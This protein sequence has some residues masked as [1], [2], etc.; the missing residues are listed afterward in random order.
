MKNLL[1]LLLS[2]SS[3]VALSQKTM[4]VIHLNNDGLI[5]GTILEDSKERIRIKTHNGNIFVFKKDEVRLV[6]K[7]P[8]VDERAIKTK[9]YINLTSAGVLVG[10]TANELRA[11]FSALM[12]HN[13]R[14]N[15]YVALGLVSG[16]EMLN[17]AT[18]PLGIN[19]KVFYPLQGGTTLFVGGTY[20]Y[21]FSV[22][23]AKDPYYK[24]T[25]S[26]GG[27]MANAELGLLFP[28]YGQLSFFL[29]AGYRYNE[30]SY[31]RNDW[32]YD[33]VD[34]TIYYNRISLRVG[35]CFY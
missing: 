27:K 4:D 30:L 31:S 9:G 24:I 26:Y 8:F 29:A 22:E 6:E 16:L 34:R 23:D 13:Y 11:P 7:V 14:F 15:P 28:S 19:V 1:L 35:V 12:E 3:I 2:L 17:E 20:G 10:S 21:S 25:D 32:Y 5:Q 18:V 33:T